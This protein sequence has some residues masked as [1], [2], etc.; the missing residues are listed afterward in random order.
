M[1]TLS[2]PLRFDSFFGDFQAEIFVF[3]L[4]DQ[5]ALQRN[6]S[7]LFFLTLRSFFTNPASFFHYVEI[8]YSRTLNYCKFWFLFWVIFSMETNLLFWAYLNL[9]FN[10]NFGI[11][12]SCS[13]RNFY[14]HKS[15]S[16]FW[17]R[18]R[19]RSGAFLSRQ[20]DVFGEDIWDV[21]VR[22]FVIKRQRKRTSTM[23]VVDVLNVLYI[24]IMQCCQQL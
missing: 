20:C 2:L 6:K 22:L 10:G 13:L 4:C 8:S 15:H 3:G 18:I 7:S 21:G 19:W 5:S 1:P 24:L 11:L 16:S 12:R 23:T 17:E 14:R 9:V